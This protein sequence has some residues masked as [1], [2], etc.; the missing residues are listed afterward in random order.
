MISR[1]LEDT[2][3]YYGMTFSGFVEFSTCIEK[4]LGDFFSVFFRLWQAPTDLG[5]GSF[6]IF[7]VHPDPW[8][9]DEI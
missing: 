4:R 1:Q 9:N 2:L 3:N 5:G 8:G 7:C 6:N